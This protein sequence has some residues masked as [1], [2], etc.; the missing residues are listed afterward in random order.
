[1]RM[2]TRCDTTPGAAAEEERARANERGT[3]AGSAQRKAVRL[4]TTALI[5][6]CLRTLLLQFQCIAGTLLYPPH[7]DEGFISGPASSVLVK[8][9]LRPARFSYPS[10]P[11]YIAA[12]RR[13]TL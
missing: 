1:M 8:A 12:A 9:D 6:L 2:L 3:V 4:W 5:V 7:A 13:R 10:L 11:T